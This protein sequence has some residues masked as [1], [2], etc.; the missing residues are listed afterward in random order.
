MVTRWV[1]FPSELF[2]VTV[3]LYFPAAADGEI[4]IATDVAH[5][6]L[7]LID[8][9]VVARFAVTAVLVV[10]ADK[11]IVPLYLA[12]GYNFIVDVWVVPAKTV[13]LEG[14]AYMLKFGEVVVSEEVGEGL[15]VVVADAKL[16]Q[17]ISNATDARSIRK[18]IVL[19]FIVG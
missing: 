10:T 1:N 9:E 6:R 14:E 4:V 13:K 3:T 7:Y 12:I 15:V 17:P 11:F 16:E 19:V 2:P 8:T 5:A 18:I